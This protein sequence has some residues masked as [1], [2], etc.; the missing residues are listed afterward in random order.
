MRWPLLHTLPA[1]K[2]CSPPFIKVYKLMMLSL[3]VAGAWLLLCYVTCVKAATWPRRHMQS[4]WNPKVMCIHETQ[5]DAWGWTCFSMI[6][7]MPLL[8]VCFILWGFSRAV[9]W[10][11]TLVLGQLINPVCPLG[12]GMCLFPAWGRDQTGTVGLGEEEETVLYPTS[13]FTALRVTSFQ[14]LA[15]SPSIFW[16]MSKPVSWTW[17]FFS[18]F[19]WL[20]LFP[21]KKEHV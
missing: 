3:A 16:C 14:S 11:I 8:Y 6:C 5:G 21:P 20:V 19:V 18:F 4:S 10:I 7:T 12:L 9:S 17:V 2:S 15:L 1:I 13:K